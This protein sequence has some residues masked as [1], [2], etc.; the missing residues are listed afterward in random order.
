M[1]AC[2]RLGATRIVLHDALKPSSLKL[3][4]RP[5]SSE[6]CADLAFTCL[7][8]PIR[9]EQ[10]RTHRNLPCPFTILS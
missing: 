2:R 6:K 7:L 8:A 9:P 10:R 4:N 3:M 1:R 5:S